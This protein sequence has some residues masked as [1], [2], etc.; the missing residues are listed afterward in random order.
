VEQQ[1]AEVKKGKG[2]GKK[3]RKQVKYSYTGAISSNV[4]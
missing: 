4:L 3:V 1:S 2:S